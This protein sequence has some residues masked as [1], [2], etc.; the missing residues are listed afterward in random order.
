VTGASGAYPL[1]WMTY[2]VSPSPKAWLTHS[3]APLPTGWLAHGG[4]AIGPEPL[5][6]A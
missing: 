6:D 2:T 1:P 3:A 4:G 5:P